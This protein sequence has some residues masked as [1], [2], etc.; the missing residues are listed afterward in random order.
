MKE[1]DHWDKAMEQAE[2]V[3]L[4]FDRLVRIYGEPRDSVDTG[5]DLKTIKNLL[6]ELRVDFKDAKASVLHEDKE[7]E[8]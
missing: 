7:R 3:F 5:N 4:D 6:L 1:V 8:L 2:E